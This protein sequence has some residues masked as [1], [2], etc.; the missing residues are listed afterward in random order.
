M[1]PPCHYH[2]VL[3]I[4][5]LDVIKAR[6]AKRVKSKFKLKENGVGLAVCYPRF[7]NKKTIYAVGVF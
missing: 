7:L 5:P 2:H 3:T 4:F 1:A 6:K